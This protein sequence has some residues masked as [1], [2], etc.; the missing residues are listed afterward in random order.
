V[1][2]TGLG[3]SVNYGIVQRLG[4]ELTIESTE[5]EGT[6][7][8]FRLAVADRPVPQPAAPL[9]PPPRALRVLVIDDER[10][11]R[12]MLSDLLTDEGHETLEAAS[13]AEGLQRLESDPAIDVVLSDLGMPGMTGWD[14]ARAVKMRHPN[15]PVVLVTGWGDDPTGTADNKAAADVVMAKPITPMSLRAA[16]ARVVV[17]AP[18]RS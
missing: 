1:K 12:E 2:S 17:G 6:T 15:M 4:G 7:I 10:D 3:L 5:G 11:V 9:A 16:L 8:T 13:G 14:V 18:G